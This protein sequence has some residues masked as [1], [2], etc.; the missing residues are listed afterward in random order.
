MIAADSEGGVWVLRYDSNE[1]IEVAGD[2]D[3]FET[4]TVMGEEVEC[5][6]YTSTYSDGSY[7]ITWYTD[8]Y[9]MPVFNEQ[10]DSDGSLLVNWSLMDTNSIIAS[11]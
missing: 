2:P 9:I 7:E 8:G 5:Y 1:D 6:G 11:A 3:V 10:Y 4:R